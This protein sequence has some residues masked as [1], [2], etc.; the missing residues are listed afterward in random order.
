MLLAWLHASAHVAL[1]HGG[2]TLISHLVAARH[3]DHDDESAPIDGE[4]QQHDL[5]EVTAAQFTKSAEHQSLVPHWVPLYDRL[6]VE[7]AEMLRARDSLHEHSFAGES[8]PDE[9]ASGWLLVVRT[10]HPVRG[11]SLT[12]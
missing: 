3:H 12:A 6:I 10:A 2:E 4:S 9:R 5:G 11:P 1:E 7:V 8:P